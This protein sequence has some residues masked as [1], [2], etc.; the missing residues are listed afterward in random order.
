M[1]HTYL[2]KMK[3]RYITR[4]NNPVAVAQLRSASCGFAE[5]WLQAGAKLSGFGVAQ[6][7]GFGLA[8]ALLLAQIALVFGR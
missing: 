8:V 4:P 2:H 6:P 7:D 3:L 1:A 5:I